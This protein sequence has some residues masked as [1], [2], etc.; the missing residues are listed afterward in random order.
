M[1]RWFLILFFACFGVTIEV[2]F[3]AT[4][5]VLDNTPILGKSIWTL[6]GYSYIWMMPIYA[7][8]PLIGGVVIQKISSRP[9]LLRLLIYTTIILTIEFIAGGILE[10]FTG[11]CPWKY[12]SGWHLCGWARLDY[13]PAWMLFAGIIEYL[14]LFMSKF[15]VKK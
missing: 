15:E 2:I 1:P 7:L 8:I 5:N 4:A 13:A 6:A 11:N 9:Y 14:Y 10:F 3:V 12:T